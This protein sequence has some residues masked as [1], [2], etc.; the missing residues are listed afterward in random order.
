L[1][2]KF[3]R[4][5][6][7]ASNFKLKLRVRRFQASSFRL[8]ASSFEAPSSKPTNFRL[9]ASSLELESLRLKLEASSFNLQASSPK[10]QDEVRSFKHEACSLKLEA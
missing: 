5:E 3:S 4:F 6:S 7:Q 8:Q 9:Q 2:L 10:P 1:K